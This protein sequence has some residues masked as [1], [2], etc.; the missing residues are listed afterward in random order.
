MNNPVSGHTAMVDTSRISMW[1]ARKYERLGGSRRVSYRWLVER[2]APN[3]Q[4]ALALLRGC[5]P[6]LISSTGRTG[7]NWL[8]ELLD[9]VQ[10]A[11]VVHEPVPEEQFYHAEALTHPEAALPY[12]RDFRLREMALRIKTRNP[13]VY[14]E[15]NG[16][17]RRHVGALRR[18]IP[19]FHIVHLV[20]DG[21]DVVTS[22]MNR[23]AL[24]PQDKI[25]G[26]FQPPADVIDASEWQSMDRFA[27][28]C[29]MWA[30]ENAH[31][32]ENTEHRAKF[33]DITTS[34]ER[35][36]EQI[37]NPL[38]LD[39]D[40]ATW[41]GHSRKPLNATKVKRYP[42][43]DGWTD[44]EKHTFWHLCGKEMAVYGYSR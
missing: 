12:M 36:K 39:L 3:T 35:F 44:A 22:V 41:A 42:E 8:A 14:G 18:L 2:T 26:K 17:L 32:R 34:Y 15:V 5:R 38:G 16:A 4:V 27:R 24:T 19:Q 7:T 37:L 11:Y 29:W 21:R 6:F 1:I 10:R 40:K 13:A 9:Q 43:Y 20:R 30:H 23:N 33:E 31:L 28:L 25:Y